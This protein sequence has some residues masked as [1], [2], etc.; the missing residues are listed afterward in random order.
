ML[1]NL[2]MGGNP[3]SHLP[4]TARLLFA[5]LE[6]LRA[7]VAALEN[8]WELFDSPLDRDI[9][10]EIVI[11]ETGHPQTQGWATGSDLG[12]TYREAVGVAEGRRDPAHLYLKLGDH[13]IA[14]APEDITDE[15]RARFSIITGPQGQ[16]PSVVWS[17]TVRPNQWLLR[18]PATSEA[19]A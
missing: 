14:V 17:D 13:S 10:I 5:E 19:K 3:A 11:P 15:S 18:S 8:A 9:T 7:R 6:A 16:I 2:K 1:T 12:D 4:A